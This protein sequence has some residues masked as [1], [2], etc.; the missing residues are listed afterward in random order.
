MLDSSRF[1]WQDAIALCALLL[2]ALG[3]G[4]GIG[5]VTAPAPAGADGGRDDEATPSPVAVERAYNATLDDVEGQQELQDVL[6]T[7]EAFLGVGAYANPP[8][9]GGS[10]GEWAPRVWFSDDG[11]RW[12]IVDYEETWGDASPYN[13]SMR[14][15]TRAPDNTFLAVGY[16][17][18]YD[19]DGNPQD[20]DGAVWTSQDGRAWRAVTAEGVGGRGNQSMDGVTTANGVLVA[21]GADE[22]G[23]DTNAAVWTSEDGLRWKRMGLQGLSKRGTQAMAGVALGEGR[24][25][26]VGWD[27]STETQP[28]VPGEGAAPSDTAVWTSDDAETWTKVGGAEL[29]RPRRQSM[30]AVCHSGTRGLWVAVGADDALD[31]DAAVWTST[32]GSTWRRHEDE[33]RDLSG[34]GRQEMLGISCNSPLW[35]SVGRETPPGSTAGGAT[36]GQNGAAWVLSP[37]AR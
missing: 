21:V 35:I 36:L 1:S 34:S 31:D 15:V 24:L 9:S 6:W 10:W 4:V 14:S 22:S 19:A 23:N 16:K 11:R 18:S 2:T 30:E 29:G 8:A 3:A 5:R 32:D 27:T 13:M 33:R 12:N 25:V 17:W 7:G 26:A 20:G 37:T 28:S